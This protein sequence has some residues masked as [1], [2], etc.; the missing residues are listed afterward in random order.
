MKKDLPR[1]YR[2]NIKK[3]AGN[4]LRV[5]RGITEIEKSPRITI[6]ELFK[7]NQIYRQNVEIETENQNLTTKIIGRTQD[8]IITIKN[9]V[10]KISDIKK[11]RLIK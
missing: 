11:I 9:E 2:G 6:D 1:I 5:A 4:N 7:E 3:G 10:I 8:H